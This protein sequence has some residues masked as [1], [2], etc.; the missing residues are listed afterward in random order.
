MSGN[1]DLLLSICLAGRNDNYGFNFKYRFVQAMNFLA[2][3]AKRAGVYDRIEVVFADWNSETP[4]SDSIALSEDAAG[5]VRFIVIPPEIAKG[6][7]PSFSPFS[8]SIAFN[9]AFRRARGQYIG[10]MPADVLI[11][12]HS[13]RALVHILSGDSP[14][15]FDKEH[16]VFAVP[17]K[18]LPFSLNEQAYFTSP[19]AIESL[20]LSG[21]AYM[22]TEN[23]ARGL[24][25]GYGAFF[26][27]RDRMFSLRGV[28]ERI[29][30]W[31]YND[32][33]LSLRC[34]D[35]CRAVNLSGYGVWSYDFE[36]S[37]R[38]SAQKKRRFSQVYEIRF[39]PAC[40][41][42][43]W[44]LGN[45]EL[46]EKQTIRFSAANGNDY[47]VPM[48]DGF[49]F[50][51]WIG[52]LLYRLPVAIPEISSAALA[53]AQ[54]SL[55]ARVRRISVMGA[56]DPSIP[57][58]LS[59]YNS[60]PSLKIHSELAG[61]ESFFRLWRYDIAL[62]PLHYQGEVKYIP[63]L[64]FLPDEMPELIIYAGIEPD[65]KD[66]EPRI[67][68]KSILIFSGCGVPAE[69]SANTGLRKLSAYGLT[70]L[71]PQKILHGQETADW[72]PMNGNWLFKLLRAAGI[73]RRKEAMVKLVRL[74][75]R[76]GFQEWRR[77]ILD[78]LKFRKSER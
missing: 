15:D 25:G 6:L 50:R 7:N 32:I 51:D 47:S 12:S 53:A 71:A 56:D 35:R 68:G 75:A 44:G 24:I 74:L 40:N 42:E 1:H 17:R 27:N 57:A 16:A 18:N 20:L 8:Q 62:A 30:G 36:P 69:L 63:S 46:T 34:S 11:T 52:V 29:A 60:F 41:T 26:L 64:E 54:L 4:L 77:R 73:F 55:R 61:E 65:W 2:W 72:R 39:G 48:P 23:A 21:N 58:V 78:F 38:M 67:T 66:L 9:A 76:A 45:I 13:L 33:D 28:D 22:L 37:P 14:V 31:G 59:L 5:L 3:S 10:L 70:V 19:E 43:N 49:S